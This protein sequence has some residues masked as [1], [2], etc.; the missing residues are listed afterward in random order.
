MPS[1]KPKVEKSKYVYTS[2]QLNKYNELL[3]SLAKKSNTELKAAL[4][5]NNQ[6]QTANG[7]E[8]LIKK[9]ADGMV[10]G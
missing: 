4:K 8:E 10:L 3:Q 7:K 9:V 2:E 6:S 5:L 1:L